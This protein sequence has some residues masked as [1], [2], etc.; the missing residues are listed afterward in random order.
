M[1]RQTQLNLEVRPQDYKGFI[2]DSFVK[3]NPK[4]S[5]TNLEQMGVTINK[6][7]LKDEKYMNF[8]KKF[9][10]DSG[11]VNGDPSVTTPIQFAQLWMPDVINALYRGRTADKIFGSKNVGTWELEEIVWTK[12]TLTG[13]PN[14]Y[15]DFARANLASYNLNFVKRDTIRFEMGIEV[16][17][18]EQRRAAQ[19][20][21]NAHGLKK[22]AVDL[23]FAILLNHIK[24]FGYNDGTRRIYGALAAPSGDI[25]AINAAKAFASAT[26]DEMITM[27]QSWIVTATK[28]LAGNYLPEDVEATFVFPLS[29]YGYLT[30]A[31]AYNLTPLK[32]MKENYPKIDIRS[33]PELDGA[34]SDGDNVALFYVKNVD[35]IGSTIDLLDTSRLRL[36]GAVPTTKGFEESYSCS[37]AGAFHR[38][39]L[40]F[41]VIEGV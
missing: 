15:D 13:K 41:N 30:T 38:C 12:L 37:T 20:R 32:W 18:L 28:R 21:Q 25:S 27:L 34:A 3:E 29:A 4:F 40:A 1:A 22:N 39:P 17:E 19:M 24:W 10:Q 11:L 6:S 5:E 35:T 9:V 23:G 8:V 36:I 31:N 7:L 26:C 2:F 33:A 14:I 16:T